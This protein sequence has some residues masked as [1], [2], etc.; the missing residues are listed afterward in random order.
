MTC[1][2]P[3]HA[4]QSVHPNEGGKHP[5]FFRPPKD[6]KNSFLIPCGKCLGCKASLALM[7]SIRCYNESLLYTQNS[8]LTLTYDDKSLPPNN[9]LQK[10]DFQKF[11][12][13]LRHV[14]EVRYFACGE[15]GDLS[16][17]PHYHAIIFGRDFLEGSEKIN[18]KLYL[19]SMVSKVWGHGHVS[20]G[21]VTPESISY[22]TGYV[23]KKIGAS[24]PDGLE[25]EFR[26]MSRRS[27]IGKEFAF[28]HLDDLIRTGTAV[29]GGKEY[30]IPLQ[31][32]RWL[33][34]ELADVKEKR[35]QA[36]NEIPLEQRLEAIDR[37][38]YMAQNAYSPNNSL[39]RASI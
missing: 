3:I 27:G 36:Y 29:M 16:R 34:T 28:K 17:R 8:F 19:N 18:E 11:I 14:A 12:K 4:H 26:V 20:I 6:I 33:E 37:L 7:W 39:K 15:Y 9:S 1:F 31:Y 5:L 25:P 35:R 21:Q 2:Y 22:V 13:R 10:S 38:K 32:F 24:A 30:P 23:S